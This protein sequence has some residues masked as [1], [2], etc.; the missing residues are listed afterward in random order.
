M[1]A[2]FCMW[3]CLSFGDPDQEAQLP[4]ALLWSRRNQ[5]ETCKRGK[6]ILDSWKTSLGF[7]EGNA[8]YSK[9]PEIAKI[10]L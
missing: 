4:A 2:K 9:K 3:G 10:L 5:G 8:A 7:E 6:D 1:T